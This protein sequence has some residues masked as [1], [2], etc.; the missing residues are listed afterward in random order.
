[1]VSIPRDHVLL[2]ELG[3]SACADLVA[4]ARLCRYA[5]MESIFRKGDAETGLMA[6]LRGRIKLSSKSLDGKEI[7]FDILD[8]GRIFGEVAMLDGQPRSHDATALEK[9]ELLVLSRRDVLPLLER[10]PQICLRMMTQLC[11]RLRRTDEMVEDLL[12]LGLGPR[13]AKRLLRLAERF[14]R[15]APAGGIRIELGFNQQD[16]ASLVGMT[17]ES[18]NKQIGRWREV[19]L[20]EVERGAITLCYP[21]RLRAIVESQRDGREGAAIAGNEAELERDGLERA[22]AGPI[23]AAAETGRARQTLHLPAPPPRPTAS[24]FLKPPAPPRGTGRL[25]PAASPPVLPD[26]RPHPGP[27]TPPRRSRSPHA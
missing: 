9:S 24:A 16:W 19:G 13:L 12:F 3:L 25:A 17:R 4:H 20:V 11:A 7:L 26:R 10:H 21:A 8:P 2:R 1:M 18:I 15:P 14:G 6:V 5:P 27:E 22:G 23:A